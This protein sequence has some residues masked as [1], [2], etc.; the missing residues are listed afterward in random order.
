MAFWEYIRLGSSGGERWCMCCV[1]VYVM[2][3]SVQHRWARTHA[4]THTH[5]QAHAHTLTHTHA[6]TQHLVTLRRCHWKIHN[7]SPPWQLAAITRFM[8]PNILNIISFFPGVSHC[9]LP[10]I[11]TRAGWKC[12]ARLPGSIPT[13][14]RSIPDQGHTCID[15]VTVYTANFSQLTVNIH[16]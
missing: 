4:R 10:A 6:H 3:A 13:R 1:Y 5:T 7:M 12:M 14:T 9:R 16:L 11:I 2:R 15:I 8:Y